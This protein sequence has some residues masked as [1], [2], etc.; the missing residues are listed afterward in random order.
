MAAEALA[1]SDSGDVTDASI[2]LLV[3]A[4]IAAADAICCTRLGQHT[5]G[6]SHHD[7]VALVGRVDRRHARNLQTLLDLKTKSGYASVPSS[8][9][10]RLRA[11][12]A[13]RQLVE[14]AEAL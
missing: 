13:A 8:T 4:G 1:A 9:A 11:A 6:D 14:A 3:H 12:R 10:D 5:Q 2:T 7:A